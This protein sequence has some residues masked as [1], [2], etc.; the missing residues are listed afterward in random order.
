MYNKASVIKLVNLY[1]NKAVAYNSASGPRREDERG[2]KG[3]TVLAVVGTAMSKRYGD[4]VV[5]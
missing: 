5:L 2:V 4:T 1:S 3:M